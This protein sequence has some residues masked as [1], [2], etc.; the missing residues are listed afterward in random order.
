MVSDSI[1]IYEEN[2]EGSW[3]ERKVGL[4]VAPGSQMV[5]DE[6]SGEEAFELKE[7]ETVF[8]VLVKSRLKQ[9]EQ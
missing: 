2:L 3:M 4:E 1:A 7:G 6:L 8:R 9:R 5:S